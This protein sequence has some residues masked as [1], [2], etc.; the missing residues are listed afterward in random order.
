[1]VSYS[2]PGRYDIK[3][4]LTDPY[5]CVDT[6]LR[7]GYVVVADAKATFDMSDSITTCPPFLVQFTNNSASNVTNIWDFGNGNF[8]NL[9][10]PAHTFTSSGDFMVKLTVI[11]NGGCTDSTYR[12]V[13]IR[14]PQGTISYDPLV[15]CAPMTVQFQSQ[16]VNTQTYV[17]DFSDGITRV[18]T[19]PSVSHVYTGPGTYIP[20]VILEDGK[21]CK[22]PILGLDTIIVK[23]TPV[24]VAGPNPIACLGQT[25]NLNATGAVT[26]NWDPHPTLSC[27]DCAT[28]AATPTGATVYRVSGTDAFGCVGTDTALV[29]VMLPGTLSVSL[30]DTLCVGESVPIRASG[31]DR[32][33]W[34]PATGLNNPS[35]PNPIARPAVTTNYVVTATDTLGCFTATGTVPVVVYPIP[36]FDIIETVIKANVGSV[37]PIKSSVSAD[38]TKYLWS[39]SLGLSCATCAEPFVTVERKATYTATVMNDGG[40]V[41]QDAL[42]IDPTC[43]GESIFIPNTF[44]PNGDGNNDVFYPRGSGISRIK[45]MQIFNRWGEMVYERKDFVLNDPTAGW[46]GTYKGQSLTPDVYVY[47]MEVICGNN[48]TF[49]KRGNVTL[50]K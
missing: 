43:T 14:G 33:Q 31:F 17:W 37:I 19:T 12:M 48:E 13:Y 3:L 49:T 11:G 34:L 46:N 40:C 5:G 38:V 42:S 30:G 26:Y 32:Y 21:G 4:T 45:Y 28:P 2:T 44:S 9:I 39:P 22:I 27:L 10:N 7:P 15:D 18:T 25:V 6:L 47:I 29:R 1:M 50:I 24:V 8:S 20:R 35:I 41:A 23:D 16:A 36:R